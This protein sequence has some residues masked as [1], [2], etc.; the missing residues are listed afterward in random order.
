MGDQ[1]CL[2]VPSDLGLVLM[3][4]TSRKCDCASSASALQ[5]GQPDHERSERFGIAVMNGKVMSVSWSMR[6]ET[7]LRHLL[8]QEHGCRVSLVVGVNTL[9]L[10][11]LSSGH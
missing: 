9:Q 8:H 11:T 3:I 4:C 1:A 5:G 10:T 6:D 2:T 7:P